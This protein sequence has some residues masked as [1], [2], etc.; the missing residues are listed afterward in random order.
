MSIP[1]TPE[2]AAQREAN[3]RAMVDPSDPKDPRNQSTSTRNPAIAYAVPDGEKVP[4]YTK[5]SDANLANIAYIK[6][7]EER[8]LRYMDGLKG[9]GVDERWLALAVTNLQMA[10]MCLIRSIAKPQRIA[11]PEDAKTG[12]T[13]VTAHD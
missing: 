8:V 10:A 11:L 2:E 1:M 4:G 13:D 5:Q 9:T 7:G 12:E 3:R 6:R